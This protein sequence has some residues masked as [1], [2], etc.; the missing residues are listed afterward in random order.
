MDENGKIWKWA[1]EPHPYTNDF[2]VLVTDSDIEA[3][4]AILYAAEMYLYD[5]N[6]G[7]DE[8]PNGSTRTL[9]VTHHP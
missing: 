1:I 6:D 9:K 8:G 4:E 2:D 7:S 5:D 3:R